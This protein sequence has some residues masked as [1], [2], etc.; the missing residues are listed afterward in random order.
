MEAAK[1]EMV[2][3]VF[4]LPNMSGGGTERV[5][6][7]LANEYVNIGYAVDILL[8][9][10]N[11]TIYPLD[12][13]VK[14]VVTGETS[15]GN[16]FIRLKRLW[17]MRQFYK[18]NKG[19]YIFAFSV[20]GAVFSV[21]AAAGIP[22]MLLVSERNDPTKMH[23]KG[24][25]DWAYQKA[26][27]LVV[28]TEDAILCFPQKLQKKAVVIPNPISNDIP[29]VYQGERE[30]KIVSVGR[31]ESQKN[32]MLLLQAF[33]EFSTDYPDYELHIYGIGELEKELREKAN[34][35]M[36]NKKVVFQGFSKQV[37]EEIINSSMFVLSSDYEGIS[38][39]MMEALAMGIPVIST[40]CPIGGARAHIEDGIS[41]I[42]TP[43]GDAAA[44]AGAMKKLAG[45][46]QFAAAMGE[47]G[48]K[49]KDKCSSKNIA[50]AFLKEAKIL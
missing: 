1:T 9:A 48:V 44:L 14:V 20:M 15:N 21:F 12:E 22:H 26:E 30:K 34:E 39:S 31:L 23:H 11:Q 8:F 38:N 35:L 33:A 10:G 4:V 32:H 25:R 49:I 46:P 40:D 7:L 17:R 16:P 29:Q 24:L 28:Q 6:A 13:R 2:K 36:I 18:A 37:K 5:V 43:V 41:G 45:N 3:I 27:K 19:C 47:Q 50:E 42:L